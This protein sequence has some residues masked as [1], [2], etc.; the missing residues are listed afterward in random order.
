ME[1]GA[2]KVRVTGP[3]A[4]FASGFA[5]EL[6][7]RGYAYSSVCSWLRVMAHLSRWMVVQ[8]LD[9][10]E[11]TRP[12]LMQF[13][14]AR[15]EAGYK[16]WKSE[17][18][19]APLVIYLVG[20]GAMPAS[21]AE[22]GESPVHRLL[23]A[24]G[25]HLL[26]EPGVKTTTIAG[27]RSAVRPFVEQRVRRGRLE[28]GELRAADVT[29]FVLRACRGQQVGSAKYL[30]TALRSLL[31]YRHLEGKAPDLAAA[32]PAVAGWRGSQLPRGLEQQQVARM[33]AACGRDTVVGRRD[34][35][36]LILLARLGL[37]R[38]EV[39]ALGLDDLD[40]R[41]GEL[42]IRGKGDRQERL[43]LPTDVGEAVSAYLLQ[44]RPQ[45]QS[46]R[47]FVS[48]RAPFAALT[49]GALQ[50]VV[51]RACDRAGIARFAPHRL[52]HTVATE[53]LR[54]GAGLPDVG[55]ILRHRSLSTTAIYAKVDR[56]ALRELVQPWPRGSTADGDRTALRGLARPWPGAAV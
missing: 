2:L 34:Y 25:R 3:L 8:G 4:A 44:D 55:Q 20:S 54:A 45:V 40:W 10:A 49:S 51:S 11:L 19:L 32:V 9:G 36:M 35:A 53:L 48:A 38:C 27:Y 21:E 52:R 16:N 18:G 28:L 31:R 43:P 14:A 46:R 24:Y 42:I 26:T 50:T 33:L 15:R 29:G 7:R 1:S 6:D 23:E 22:A 5:E 13:V 12:R 30:V 47:L 17:R 37:R 39:A 41:R 56:T